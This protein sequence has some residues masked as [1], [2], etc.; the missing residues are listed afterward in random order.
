MMVECDTCDGHGSTACR[1]TTSK[2][3]AGYCECDGGPVC[4]ACD[5]EGM[6]EGEPEGEETDA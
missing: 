4:P 3:D 6:V 5:G 1:R 2:C